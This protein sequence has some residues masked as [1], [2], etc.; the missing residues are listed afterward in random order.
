MI[1][2]NGHP[3]PFEKLKQNKIE[4]IDLSNPNFK[5]E[6][7]TDV[8]IYYNSVRGL[9]QGKPIFCGGFNT[10]ND[11]M[12]NCFVI[13]GKPSIKLQMLKKRVHASSVVLQKNILWVVGGLS[14]IHI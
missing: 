6:L 12:Q 9:L 4:I 1:V 3:L 14:L 7:P 13:G 10:S 2:V 11:I 8:P 5:C